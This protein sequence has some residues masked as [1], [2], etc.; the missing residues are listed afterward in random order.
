[1][2]MFVVLGR[3]RQGRNSID[4]Q[5]NQ[6]R[7]M[8]SVRCEG[9]RKRRQRTSPQSANLS[10]SSVNPVPASISSSRPTSSPML[11][12]HRRPQATIDVHHNIVSPPSTAPTTPLGSTFLATSFTSTST[13]P[14]DLPKLSCR[15]RPAPTMTSNT[16]CGLPARLPSVHC[17]Q[18]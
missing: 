9:S 7:P 4:L 3:V 1:M 15:T 8:S 18:S 16:S 13:N 5:S 12:I 14:N 10:A 17:A 11:L 6:I 2:K